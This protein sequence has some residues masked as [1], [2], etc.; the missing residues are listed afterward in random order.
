ELAGGGELHLVLPGGHDGAGLGRGRQVVGRRPGGRR[1]GEGGR[2]GGERGGPS[3]RGHV[4]VSVR[5]GRDDVSGPARADYPHGR[6]KTSNRDVWS[7]G[8]P[9]HPRERSVGGRRR[10][11]RRKKAN[12]SPRL[13]TPKCR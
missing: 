9:G 1:D 13:D 5:T 3:E 8:M 11:R 4:R 2:E 6:G 10:K 12:S 7:A